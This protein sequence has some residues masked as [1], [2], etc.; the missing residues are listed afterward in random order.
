MPKKNPKKFCI[1]TDFG[2]GDC[3]MSTVG[4]RNLKKKYPNCKIYVASVYPFV[5]E[6]N[7]HIEKVYQLGHPDVQEFYLNHVRE[8]GFSEVINLKWY[9]R[10]YHTK[11][12]APLSKASCELLGVPFDEDKTELYLTDEERLFARSFLKSFHKPIVLIQGFGSNVR[13]AGQQ[14]TN[15]KDWLIEGWNEVVKQGKPYFHFIQVGGNGEPQIEGIDLNL[16]G[17]TN[18]R[19]SFALISECFTFMAIDSFLQ[20]AAL[21]LDKKGIVLFGRSN[22]IILGHEFHMNIS[23]PE[24]CPDIYCGRPEGGFGDMEVR[25]GCFTHWNCPHKNCMRAIHP[26]MVLDKLM[27]YKQEEDNKYK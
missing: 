1:C 19:Q 3:I 7:P 10:N 18:W 25:D 27:A 12:N 23:V 21:A 26:Q 9:E 20:H 11:Y 24:S 16:C 22:P 15:V 13:G 8:C 5:Y 6:N 14:M 17:K 2:V 4:I